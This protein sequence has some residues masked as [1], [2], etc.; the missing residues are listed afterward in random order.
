MDGWGVNAFSIDE[1]FSLNGNV[2]VPTFFSRVWQ[3]VI[4]T[5]GYFIWKERNARVF[6]NKVSSTN[7]IVQDI[8]IKSFEWVVRRSNKYKVVDWQ[9]WLWDP[10]NI[11]IQ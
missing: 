9:H 2:N 11:Q 4:W 10:I 3:A 1:F 5:S 7:K 8:Q 6:G